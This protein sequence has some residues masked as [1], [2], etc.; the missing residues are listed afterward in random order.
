MSEHLTADQIWLTI[1]SEAEAIVACDPAF[2]ASLYPGILEHAGLGS[3]LARKIGERLGTTADESRRFARIATEAFA[4]CPELIEAASLD[5]QSVA[6]NDP[7]TKSLLP[8]FVN[9]KGYVALQAG[10]VDAAMNSMQF[11]ATSRHLQVAKY[12]SV[13]E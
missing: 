1:R 12:F 6:A 2:G 7:A 9:Y 11:Y 13:T 3:A 4:A 5:L 8:P 10:V